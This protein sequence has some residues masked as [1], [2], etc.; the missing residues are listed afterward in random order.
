MDEERDK[1]TAKQK[2]DNHVAKWNTWARQRN[3]DVE[4]ILWV[5][6]TLI[7]KLE[8]SQKRGRILFWF[9]NQWFDKKWYAAR[10][11]EAEENAGDRYSPEVNVDLSIN[12]TIYSLGCADEF[13]E[14]FRNSLS[15]LRKLVSSLQYLER[16]YQD[17]FAEFSK[18]QFYA[19]QVNNNILNIVKHPVERVDIS[20]FS[21]E[22][23]T[24]VKIVDLCL[25]YLYS[26][27][28]D[29]KDSVLSG[30]RYSLLLFRDEMSRLQ[31]Y[32]F[33]RDVEIAN[34]G[35]LLLLGDAGSGKTHLF[36]HLTN[37][38]INQGAPT[39]LFLGQM[40]YAG[41]IWK[42][43]LTILG[44]QDIDREEFLGALEASARIVGKKAV[45]FIDAL[46]ES[47][48]ISIWKNEIAGI[49]EI[50]SNYKWISIGF[51]IR[52]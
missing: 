27:A 51:S 49:V 21:E 33:S 52:K 50:I 47:A 40:F 28:E 35:L 7:N 41:N 18:L 12:S 31:E 3:Q 39:L 26:K 48:D 16:K 30:D 20:T 8:S 29:S 15:E 34:S 10:F 44:L 23:K 11:K 4:F 37:E 1:I 42:Q 46:N 5:S 17:S 43:I 2:W 38:R 13:T 25:D 24:T 36:C 14:V 45:I 32:I 22:I 9:N 6:S 19:Q